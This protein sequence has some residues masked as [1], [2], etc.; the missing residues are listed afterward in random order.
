MI[1]RPLKGILMLTKR[2]WIIVLL[3]VVLLGGMVFAN[4][5]EL[6]SATLN[7]TRQAEH[8][9]ALD[10]ASPDWD[11]YF[12]RLQLPSGENAFYI[13]SGGHLHT[14]LSMTVSGTYIRKDSQLQILY[15]APSYMIG[16]WSD[17]GGPGIV[18]RASTAPGSHNYA[19]MDVLG[20]TTFSV[21]ADGALQWGTSTYQEMDTRLY[22]ESARSLRTPGKLTADTLS[23]GVAEWTQ[24]KGVPKEACQTGSLY[25]NIHGT[26]RTTLFVCAGGRWFPVAVDLPIDEARNQQSR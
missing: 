4:L 9:S 19:G 14:A 3:T 13:N 23:V 1:D 12:L 16:A 22:R 8:G 20:N 7:V 10:L 26:A 17:V 6:G 11:G 21:E 5:P 18:S 15:P 24:G 2:K 25:S